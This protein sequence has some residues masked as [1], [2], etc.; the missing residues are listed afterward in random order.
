M[1][2]KNQLNVDEHIC[3]VDTYFLN[4]KYFF[5]FFVMEILAYF[6]NF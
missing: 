5:V 2:E 1:I 6:Y 4:D 3:I